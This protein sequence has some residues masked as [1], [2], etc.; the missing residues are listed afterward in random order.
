[1][2]GRLSNRVIPEGYPIAKKNIYIFGDTKAQNMKKLLLPVLLL[3]VLTSTAVKLAPGT[4]TPDERKSA[5]DYY[6]KT[7]AKSTIQYI[8]TTAH[9]ARHTLQLEE[10]MA[11]PGFP[12]N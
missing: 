8:G 11:T 3:T 9:T 7:K 4:L 1:M 12:K 6:G 10:V 5:I 2:S